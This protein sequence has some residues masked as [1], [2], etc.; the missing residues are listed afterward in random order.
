MTTDILTKVCT[1]CGEEK[2][3]SEFSKCKRH[4]SGILNMCKKCC[5]E[6]NK[7]WRGSNPEKAKQQN[8]YYKKH[9]ELVKEYKRKWIENNPEKRKLGLKKW[10]DEHKKEIIEAEKIRKSKWREMLGDIYV[11][12]KLRRQINSIGLDIET[13]DITPD[14]IELKRQEIRLKRIQI[15]LKSKTHEQ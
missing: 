10:R 5:N 11:K 6:K 8:N 15:Q 13:S 9:P 2:E 7:K 14:L 4:K 1:K 3:L 12:D